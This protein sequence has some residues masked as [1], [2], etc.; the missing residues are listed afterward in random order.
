MGVLTAFG[1]AGL[2]W[3]VFPSLVLNGL[4][5]KWGFA[6]LDTPVFY[7]GVAVCRGAFPKEMA[8]VEVE[9]LA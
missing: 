5:F 6:L 7:A 3:E 1:A 9:E 2:T 8:R 4:L